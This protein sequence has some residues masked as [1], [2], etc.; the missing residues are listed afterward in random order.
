MVSIAES[1]C[2]RQAGLIPNSTP[3]LEAGALCAALQHLTNAC[4]AGRASATASATLCTPIPAAKSSLAKGVAMFNKMT[5][6][7]VNCICFIR[8]AP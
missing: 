5:M 7:E 6:N 1:G 8:P 4:V 2:E 3:I